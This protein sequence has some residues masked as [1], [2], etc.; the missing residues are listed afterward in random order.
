MANGGTAFRDR[1]LS[2]AA[3]A[4]EDPYADLLSSISIGY[5]VLD[6][7]L[8]LVQANERFADMIG[9]PQGVIIGQR[10]QDSLPPDCADELLPILETVLD[11]GE[12]IDN[13]AVTG[14]GPGLGRRPLCW[15]VAAHPVRFGRAVVGV[16]VAISILTDRDQLQA[17]LRDSERKLLSLADA[18]PANIAILDETGRIVSCNRHWRNFAV[19]NDLGI[20][21][22]GVGANYIEFCDAARGVETDDAQAMARALRAVLSGGSEWECVEYPYDSPTRRAWYLAVIAPLSERRLGSV[23][24]MHF[25]ITARRETEEALRRAHGELELRVDERTGELQREVAQRRQAE[26]A[27]ARKAAEL[28]VLM[29]AAPAFILIAHDP[30]CERI[31]GNRA[32]YEILRLPRGTNLSKTAPDGGPDNFRIL[33][34]G[35]EIP[36]DQLPLQM[37]ARGLEIQDWEEEIQ[38]DGGDVRIFLGNAKPLLDEQGRISGAIAVYVDISDRK[39][40]EG[41]LR[42][43]EERYRRVVEDQTE[44]VC[45]FLPDTTIVF[46]NASCAAYLGFAPDELLGR[47]VAE[48]IAPSR[49]PEFLADLASLSPQ[50]PVRRKEGAWESPSGEACWHI[51]TTRAFFDETNT[52]VEF[53]AVGTDITELKRAE[54][55]LALAKA[56][57]EQANLSKSRFLAAASHDLRQPLQTI[58]AVWGSLSKL[59]GD[60]DGRRCVKALGEAHG[61]MVTLL[62]TLLDINQLEVGVTTPQIANFPVMTLLDRLL[63]DAEPIA[64]AKGLDLRVVRSS[65]CVRSDFGLLKQIVQNLIVNALKYT[66]DGKVLFGCRQRGQQL[67]IEVWDTGIGMAED[68]LVRIFEEFYQIDNVARERKKG[69]G[70]GLS[71]AKR[72]AD[73]LGYAV[74]VRSQPGK[75][76]VF[77]LLV[78]LGSAEVKQDVAAAPASD[79]QGDWSGARLLVIDDDPAVL[80]SLAAFLRVEA[81]E[82]L[83]STGLAGAAKE[84]AAAGRP[85]DLVIAD[86]R[87]SAENTG[88]QAVRSVRESIGRGIPGIILTGDVSR[89]LLREIKDAGCRLLHKPGD[90]DEMVAL[91]RS[92]LRQGP[93][94]S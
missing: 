7:D 52:P 12:A 25:D 55:A 72:M 91:I 29:E 64:R 48:L 23:A 3:T 92:M 78:P 66:N 90:P 41:A 68:Q 57:A 24:V 6:G 84:I 81:F 60:E 32:A 85:P 28:E 14:E 93:S 56:Q 17:E 34:G 79:D 63:V 62:N 77:S 16:G 51:W 50:E 37:A 83:T 70:L 73:L 86:Y 30:A 65:A 53:Q 19:A 38:V 58:G 43:S 76:S 82:V 89:S 69:L 75:G 61:S 8:C 9:Q 21:N 45:R 27:L 42:I 26:E 18:F 88:V 67:R 59:V 11:T 74:E 94:S 40:T 87:L 80:E 44:L 20:P 31:T 71:I 1:T 2:I 4:V 33:Q 35:V 47:K 54:E 10:V 13:A 46:A 15:Y 22:F 49:R 39:V 36:H 5:A